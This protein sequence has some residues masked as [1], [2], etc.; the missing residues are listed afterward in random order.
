MGKRELEFLYQAANAELGVELESQEVEKDFMNL[1]QERAKHKE[2][3]HLTIRRAS[4]AGKIW[5]VRLR[6]LPK[7]NAGLDLDISLEDLGL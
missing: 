1:S 5:V 4:A 2:L 6:E 3:S 7:G